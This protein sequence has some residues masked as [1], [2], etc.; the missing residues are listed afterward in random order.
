MQDFIRQRFSRPTIPEIDASQ[1]SRVA[2]THRVIDVRSSFELDGPLGSI[3]EAEN[4]SLEVLAHA[5]QAWDRSEPLVLVCRSGARSGHA[6]LMLQQMGFENVLNLRGGM[7]A[8]NA[9]AQRNAA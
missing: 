8:Y 7:I 6:T 5:A 1:L 9:L 2:Q 4:V 3:P